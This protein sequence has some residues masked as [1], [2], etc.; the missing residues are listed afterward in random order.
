[1]ELQILDNS[2]DQYRDL[3]AYQFHGS[4]YG[5]VPA[6]RGFQRPVGEWNH[7]EVIARGR[8]IIVILNGET[9]VDAD[10]DE[11]SASGT[12]DGREHPGLGRTRGH[13]GFLGHGSRV[14]FR[15]L[16]IKELK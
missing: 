11:A 16:W 4:I 14:E 13:I 8:R 15:S 2:A 5:V 9:I 1:M 3:R 6:K 10:L 7:Q 12:M